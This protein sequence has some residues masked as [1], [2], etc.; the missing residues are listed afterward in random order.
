MPKDSFGIDEDC[1][2]IVTVYVPSLK[3][4]IWVD[5]TFDAY[6]MN[7][8]GEMLS[9]AE[10]RERIIDGRPLI[11]NPDA[12]WNH[13]SSQTKEHYLY[14]YMAKNLYML[15]CYANSEYNTE[16]DHDGKTYIHVY[17]LPVE[18]F[19]QT[20]YKSEKTDVIHKTENVIYKTN[21]ADKFWAAPK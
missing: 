17:L 10:V 19:K 15:S 16:T 3:K 20:P 12:N 8:K 11:L 18:Y 14:Y 7:E 5:P 4:W 1:H 2:V 13:K 21:N 6:V 9:I